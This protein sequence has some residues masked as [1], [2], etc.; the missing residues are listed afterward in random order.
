MDN[1]L[2]S[3]AEIQPNCVKNKLIKIAFN[4]TEL[5]GI[6]GVINYLPKSTQ[7]K[8]TFVVNYHKS[9]IPFE[10]EENLLFEQNTVMI[11]II[12][13]GSHNRG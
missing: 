12:K 8:L 6:G 13:I 10:M 5:L 4:I 2:V 9:I 1:L 7:N 3:Y 11:K